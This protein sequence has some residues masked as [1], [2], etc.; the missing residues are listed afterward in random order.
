MKNHELMKSVNVHKPLH[1][2]VCAKPLQIDESFMRCK[3]QCLMVIIYKLDRKKQE[4]ITFSNLS[5][6]WYFWSTEY[7]D[8]IDN[9]M[10]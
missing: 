4:P 3:G 6:V 10:R 1:S 5:L 2:M 7:F 9:Y 8:T